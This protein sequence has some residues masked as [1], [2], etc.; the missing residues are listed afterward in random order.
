MEPSANLE[1]R[2]VRLLF[3]VGRG[4]RAFGFLCLV[5]LRCPCAASSSVI[6]AVLR[7]RLGDREGSS[8]SSPLP[9]N[10]V[11]ADGLF[12]LRGRFLGLKVDEGLGMA[13]SPALVRPSMGPKVYCLIIRIISHRRSARR[14]LACSQIPHPPLVHWW[15]LSQAAQP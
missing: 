12:T 11:A 15:A 7:E 6:F 14:L 10:W 1:G 8:S 4:D 2:G 13:S 3:R 5:D 9:I